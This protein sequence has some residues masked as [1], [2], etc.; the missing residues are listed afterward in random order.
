MDVPLSATSAHAVSI[1]PGLTL[2]WPGDCLY[3]HWDEVTTSKPPAKEPNSEIAAPSFHHRTRMQSGEH[4]KQLRLL[5]SLGPRRKGGSVWLCQTTD[6]MGQ[7]A[8]VVLKLFRP[9]L[10]PDR[11]SLQEDAEPGTMVRAAKQFPPRLEWVIRYRACRNL[12]R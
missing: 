10:L 7:V 2:D 11:S 9:T 3:G 8:H 6:E 4:T 5:Q 1:R 12:H